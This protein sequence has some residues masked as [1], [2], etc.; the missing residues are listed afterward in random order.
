MIWWSL[1]IDKIHKNKIHSCCYWCWRQILWKPSLDEQKTL[2]FFLFF[3][4]LCQ[5]YFT[6]FEL[7]QSLGGAKTG[8]PREKSHDHPQAELG[9]SHMWPELGLNPQRW[10]DERLRWLKIS[11][12]NHWPL[13]KTLDTRYKL[14]YQIKC[15]Q[16]AVLSDKHTHWPVSQTEVN[17]ATWVSRNSTLYAPKNCKKVWTPEI[18]AVIRRMDKEVIW[19]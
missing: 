9:L 16:C 4:D 10:E 5:D 15:F 19:W 11:V 8:D 3:F 7:R 17:I 14:A 6:H 2:F 18:I 13:Q 1:H 12:L